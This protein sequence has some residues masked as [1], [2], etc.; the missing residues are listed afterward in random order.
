MV[1]QNADVTVTVV[2][3]DKYGGRDDGHIAT[4][5][6]LDDWAG[7]MLNTGHAKPYNGGAR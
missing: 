3:A 4:A 6:G 7:D 1:W 2:K 5:K